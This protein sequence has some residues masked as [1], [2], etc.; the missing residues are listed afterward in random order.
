MFPNGGIN[1]FMNSTDLRKVRLELSLTQS[2]L[3]QYLK[4]PFGTYIKWEYGDRRVP[5]VVEVALETVKR[6]IKKE[7]EK[8]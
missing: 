6:Q 3:A 2:S 4:T 1:I 8:G 7:S 5:G